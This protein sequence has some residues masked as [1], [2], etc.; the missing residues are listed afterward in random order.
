MGGIPLELGFIMVLTPDLTEAEGF[1]RDVL[2]LALLDR[3]SNR[4]VF[5]LAG[6]EFRV[7]RCAEAAAEHRHAS[8]AATVCVFEV[9][10]INAAITRMRDKGV[11]FIH[12]TPAQD[13]YSGF[14]YAAFRAPGGNVR[15]I[16]ERQA[17]S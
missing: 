4:L 16:M 14:R 3:T 9:P 13:A 15:E 17:A 8:N 2:G 12:E 7:F 1:Y 5:D 11:V 6:I 10:S